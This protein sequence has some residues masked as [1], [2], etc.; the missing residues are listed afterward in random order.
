MPEGNRFTIFRKARRIW[1]IGSIHGEAAVLEE[2]HAGLASRL[3]DGDRLVYLGNYLGY[4]PQVRETIEELLAFRSAFLA[5]PP[6]ADPNDVVYLRGS[7]EEIWQKLLQLQFAQNPSEVLQWMLSH[8]GDAT[9]RAYG[10]MPELGFDCAVEGA[11]ALTHWTNELRDRLRALPGHEMLLNSLRRA[12]MTDNRTLLFVNT[13][14]DDTRTLDEQTDSFWWAGRSFKSVK[15]PFD[16]FRKI[17]RGFDPEHG[18]FEERRY[19]ITVDSGC[20][21]GGKLT[22][23]CF[24]SEGDLLDRLDF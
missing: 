15:Q 3:E 20:G 8:G 4:T 24:S 19:T 21:F 14:I 18:G 10:S 13:G 5:L 23:A 7:Q 16:G 17:V 6:Y 22:A 1:A 11:L 2:L 9:L 12:A